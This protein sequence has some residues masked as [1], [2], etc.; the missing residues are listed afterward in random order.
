MLGQNSADFFVVQ[1]FKQR[2]YP[3][4]EQQVYLR[5]EFGACRLFCY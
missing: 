5:K 2:I 1:S 3:T 4:L